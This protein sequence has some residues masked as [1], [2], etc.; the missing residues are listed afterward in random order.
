MP[1]PH[2]LPPLL[3]A[4]LLQLINKSTQICPGKEYPRG[5]GTLYQGATN[6]LD[7]VDMGRTTEFLLWYWSS[8]SASKNAFDV[9]CYLLYTYKV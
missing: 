1:S 8:A 4:T 7:K 6:H 9:C 5:V 3:I 2:T